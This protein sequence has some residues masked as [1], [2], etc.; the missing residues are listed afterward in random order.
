MN[1]YF[2]KN[3]L[4]ISDKTN[5]D[6]CDFVCNKCPLKIYYKFPEI[7]TL[8]QIYWDVVVNNIELKITFYTKDDLEC[9][10]YKKIF[11]PWMDYEQVFHFHY[12]PNIT[13]ENC[14]EKIANWLPFI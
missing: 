12:L 13:P 4:D 10:I 9:F 6:I 14:T 8:C 11:H 1:C 2:C 7:P 3:V 5:E